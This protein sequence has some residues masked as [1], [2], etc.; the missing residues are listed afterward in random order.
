MYCLA[1]LFAL[2]VFPGAVGAAATAQDGSTPAGISR[3]DGVAWMNVR[4]SSGVPLA[5][6]LFVGDPGGLGNPGGTVIWALLGLEF[7]GYMII[8]TTAIWW[9]GFALGFQWLDL[10]ASA[11]RGVADALTA[12]IAAPIVLVTAASIGAV[13]VA[14]F[15]MRGFHAKAV[16]QIVTM[17]LVAVVGPLFLAAPLAD[18]LSSD[19]LLARGRDVGVSVAAGLNGSVDQNPDHLVATIQGD[20]ADT[21]ARR[22]VQVWNFG[23]VLDERAACGAAWS[24]G[25]TAGDNEHA[26]T[27]IED[28]GDNEAVT[29]MENPSVAQLCTGLILLLSALVLLAFA[30]YL[31]GQILKAALDA[32]YQGFMAIFGFA[33]GGFV[34]G[35]SQTFLVRNLV[36]TGIAAA[37]MCVY[38]IFLGIFLLLLT[39]LFRVADGQVIAVIVIAAMVEIV[40]VLQLSRLHKG[41]SRGS[42]WGTNRFASAVQGGGA[43]TGSGGTALGMGSGGATTKG[44]GGSGL[45][46]VGT[47]AAV[48]TLNTSPVLAWVAGRTLNPLNPYARGL[49]ASQRADIATAA[50][51]Q[52]SWTWAQLAR[53]NWRLLAISEADQWGGIHTELG[54]ARALKYVDNNRVPGGHLAAVLRAAGADDQ[55]VTN[56]LRARAVQE[57]SRS[58]NPFGFAPLQ[59]AVASAYAVENHADV[60]AARAFAAQAVSAADSLA[61]HTLAPPPNAVLDHAFIR[62]VEQNWDSERAL[63]A[64]ITPDEW[65]NVGR[66]TRQAIADRVSQE[67]LTLSRAHYDNP[68]DSSRAA[69]LRSARRLANL[70]H[71]DLTQGLDPWDP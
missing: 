17:L 23:H 69:L 45:G 64:A 70:N 21:F 15:V 55:A 6:Y 60:E 42:S 34:Y 47:L 38:T 56:A 65:N 9:I 11:L 68:T 52:E 53:Q 12:Q 18:V 30:A 41:L 48:N 2:F 19:G 20:M 39:N 32:I 61:R 16:S 29:R 63:R 4:D 7:I 54:L 49:K 51:R 35:P 46:F 71:V 5:D 27:D 37:R 36:N 58:R 62:R 28:C 10:F 1:A 57:A 14:W 59:K 3:M 26:R 43:T 67:H 31:S 40:A 25:I 24:A 44:S 33:A 8:V 50:G 13:F 66:E 22:P